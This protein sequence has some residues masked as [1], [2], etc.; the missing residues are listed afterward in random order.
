MNDVKLLG[1][2][3]VRVQLRREGDRCLVQ[4]GCKITADSSGKDSE[5]MIIANSG[6]LLTPDPPSAARYRSP[7]M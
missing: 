2:I 5:G 3:E 6:P 7:R 1:R 4:R